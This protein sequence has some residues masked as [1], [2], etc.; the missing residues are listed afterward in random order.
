MQHMVF[1]SM[2][3][4]TSA[5]REIKFIHVFNTTYQFWKSWFRNLSVHYEIRTFDKTYNLLMTLNIWHQHSSSSMWRRKME[6]RKIFL[7]SK[8]GEGEK[9]F[10][11]SEVQIFSS[12]ISSMKV[13]TLFSLYLKMFINKIYRANFSF[14]SKILQLGMNSM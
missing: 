7:F 13:T 14:K 9:I 10:I 8:Q 4:S 5:Y 12:H 1:K 11:V 3:V 2:F 6:L